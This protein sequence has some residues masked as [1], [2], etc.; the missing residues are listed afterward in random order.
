MIQKVEKHQ[1]LNEYNNKKNGLDKY[2]D[3]KEGARYISFPFIICK[4]R[5]TN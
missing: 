2:N 5:L 1:R 4:N 3:E